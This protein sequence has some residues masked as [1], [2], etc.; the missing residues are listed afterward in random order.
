LGE[1]RGRLSKTAG[2]REDLKVGSEVA[3][4]AGVDG[5]TRSQGF[6]VPE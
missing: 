4:T 3:A 1:K 5:V 6:L 2:V